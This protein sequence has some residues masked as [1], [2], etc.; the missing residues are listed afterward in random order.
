MSERTISGAPLE[1]LPIEPNR[2]LLSPQLDPQ[3][4]IEEFYDPGLASRV[5]TLPVGGEQARFHE[6]LMEERVPVF[7]AIYRDESL[8]L[9]VPEGSR[10]VRKLLRFVARDI[11]TYSEV[12]YE[13]GGVLNRV[14]EAVSGVPMV[15]P[16]RG[17][18]DS[19]AFALDETEVYGGKIYLIPPY[20]IDP[21]ISA[22][23]QLGR[24]LVTLQAELQASGLFSSQEEAQLLQV[25]QE[26]WSHGR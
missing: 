20:L 18:L 5:I 10:P 6:E 16:E 14:T 23:Q 4:G 15:Q 21:D 12:F 24:A 22:P 13:L 19:F 3:Q 26:G 7:S 25:T 8:C 2:R 11:A 1:R 17:L 9:L